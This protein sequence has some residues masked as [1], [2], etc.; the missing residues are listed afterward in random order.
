M[1]QINCGLH[2]YSPSSGR[3]RQK[4]LQSLLVSCWPDR[5]V[6]TSSVIGSGAKIKV[7]S[8]RGRYYTS[9]SCFPHAPESYTPLTRTRTQMHTQCV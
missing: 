4:D 7:G 2:A 6:E 9:A 3:Q 8:E 1:K 5:L